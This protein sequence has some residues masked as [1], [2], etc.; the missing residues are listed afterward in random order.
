MG[1]GKMAME[2]FSIKDK[3]NSLVLLIGMLV[4]SL[5]YT[6][7]AFIIPL[8]F[9][10]EV[11]AIT[12]G[13]GSFFKL[14]I[15]KSLIEFLQIQT[16]FF[17]LTII[18]SL[19]FAS[20][21][22]FILDHFG[23]YIPSILWLQQFGLVKG[24]ANL[25]ILLGQ[26][27]F[28][29]L[30]QAG[31]SNVVDGYYKINILVLICYLFYIFEK[32]SWTHLL[33]IPFLYLFVQSPSPDL[34]AIVFSLMIL[35]EIILGNKNI[36]LLLGIS[37][38]VFALKPTVIWLPLFC[39]LYGFLRLKSNWK[40]VFFAL[41]IF[42]LFV[43]KN[44]YCFGFPIF[45]VTSLNFGI[46]WQPNAKILQLSSQTGIGMTGKMWGF[47]HFS[48]TPDVVSFGKKTQVCGILANKEKFDQVAHHVFVE[49]SRINSTFGGDFIDF[50]RFQL[51]LEVIEK[52][53]LVEKGL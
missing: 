28:W 45:P 26:M 18:I 29:H 17:Y 3:F 31:F 48:I 44:L 23:Y 13:I 51:I 1:W 21:Y 7:F 46:P 34:P 37:I 10:V 41:C 43:V 39:F 22:P 40:T 15:H 50:C 24:I 19:F 25:D 32:K 2:I 35:N 53:N 4:I 9:W 42:T 49:S 36:S 38:W 12:I 16:F 33:F 27:S 20:F 5:F 6:L 47:Q 30:L 11:T 14:K 8:N 52:E